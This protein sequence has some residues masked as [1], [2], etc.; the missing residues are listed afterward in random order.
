VKQLSILFLGLNS[1]TT[2]H[3]VHAMERLGHTVVLINPRDLLSHNRYL[4]SW[5]HNTGSL[6][7]GNIL[8]QRLRA[9]LPSAYFDLVWVEGGE[10]IPPRLIEELKQRY[11]CVLNYNHD[12]PYGK[13]DGRKWRLYLKSVP[14]YSLITVTRDENINEAYAQGAKDV[15]RIDRSADEVAH[16]P[17]LLSDEDRR[18]WSSE[19]V[20]VG[21]WMPERGP[22]MARLIELG[23][24]LT[25]HGHAWHKA[26]EW[27]LLKPFW[28]SAG[29][30]NDDTYAK[31]IQC[32]KVTLGLLSKGNRDVVTTRSFEVPYL[33]GVLCAE[34]TGEHRRLYREDVEAVFWSTPEECAAKCKQLLEND[35][36]RS[37]I[38]KQGRLRC[39]ANGTTHE[40][41]LQKILDRALSVK[42][43]HM[44][45]I[46]VAS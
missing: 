21:T 38:A 41:V 34:R 44:A 32:A 39:I 26:K 9:S 22:F 17:R 11:R 5:I 36:W 46:E 45:R 31:A 35:T 19:V 40:Q 30:Y 6:F 14:H 10:L 23:V 15:L 3:R 4:M 2:L 25:L 8:C 27:P 29:L 12:D 42:D 13:R 33:G 43:T 28:R 37:S 20:F 24:P 7:L 16:A 18:K 1:G